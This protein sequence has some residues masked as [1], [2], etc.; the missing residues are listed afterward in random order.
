VTEDVIVIGAGPNG[1]VAA[2]HLARAGQKP[3]VLE[4]R[5][6]VGG[7]ATSGPLHPGFTGPTLAHAMGPLRPAITRGMALER[8]GL[9]LV[10]PD[11][12]LFA[13]TPDGRAL[14]L[15]RDPGRTSRTLDRIST[16]DARRY[17]D[18]HEALARL[19]RVV[20][21]LL[22]SVPPPT[23]PAGAG[24]LWAL[25]GTAR[26]FRALARPDA[27]RL[28]RYLTL[29]AADLVE[30]WFES[31]LLRAALVTPAL[32]GV[33]GGPRS[34]G[35]GALLLLQAT[36]HGHAGGPGTFALGG[37]GELT[38]AMRDAAIEAG[39]R[40]RTESA[41]ARIEIKDGGLTGVTLANGDVLAARTVVSS[42]DPRGT[43]LG[44]A[45]PEQ[46]D[47]GFLDQVKNYRCRGT[48]AKVN[49][50]LSGL[51][52]FPGLRSLREDGTAADP[53]EVLSGRIHIGP[54]VDYLER[55]SDAAKY[56]EASAEPFLDVTIPTLID[57]SLA[58]AGCHVMSIWAQSAPYH[59]ARGTWDQH[60]DAFGDAVVRTLAAAAPGL[61]QLII[62]RE[63]I[64]PL[65]LERDY[66]LT[67]GHIHHGEPALDQ[68]FMM[69]PLFGW[70]RY[71]TPIRGLYLCGAGTHPGVGLSGDSGA[72][73]A[74]VILKDLRHR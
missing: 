74:R 61:D 68:L 42:A 7:A 57:P 48:A 19:S 12:F 20:D 41:V 43:L 4:R 1:L 23:G 25:V 13:P 8:H 28:L 60:R 49:L 69:R 11:P 6:T 10:Q 67:G 24:D 22:S 30:E 17:L 72:N 58:P 62:A 50:A 9:R 27:Y 29:P 16:A 52:T 15:G 64:T 21:P 53:Q 3:L 65:D 59:L 51:P 45:D 35:T 44:L 73:A 54:S 14:V 40:I 55:A 2:F 32:W 71:R 70:A 34:A 66:G 63:V 46:F 33:F 18:F 38:R 31:D 5:P 37:L 47:P 56:G 39:A 36:L 26:S